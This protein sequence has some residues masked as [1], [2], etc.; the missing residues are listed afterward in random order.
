MMDAPLGFVLDRQLLTGLI[1]FFVPHNLSKL[2]YL[3][4]Y[5][6]TFNTINCPV[7]ELKSMPE[8]LDSR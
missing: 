8:S 3:H 7:S 1:S 5:T 4:I 2:T 6:G